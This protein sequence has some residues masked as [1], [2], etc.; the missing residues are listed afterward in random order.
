MPRGIG[1]LSPH[2]A[3]GPITALRVLGQGY[4]IPVDANRAQRLSRRAVTVG[5]SFQFDGQMVLAI[6]E[7]TRQLIEPLTAY[8]GLGALDDVDSA[9]AAVLWPWPFPKRPII[10]HGARSEEVVELARTIHEHTT[11]RDFPFTQVN[12]V[13][14]SDVAI[15][16]LCTQGGC[17]T[18]FLDLTTPVELPP[19]LL[20]HLFADQ[21]H[22]RYHLGTIAVTSVA[23]DARRCLGPGMEFYPLCT[24]GF[25]RAPWHSAMRNVTF[26]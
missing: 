6:D 24:I 1:G 2:A 25:R 15:E 18:L 12:T 4:E 9:L 8:C 14:T 7:L 5:A 16:A 26:T 19:L 20:R 10:L 17:G 13:P 21:D 3:R 11:R 22:D 23:E